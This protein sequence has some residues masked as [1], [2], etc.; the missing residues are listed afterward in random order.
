MS[1]P[2]IYNTPCTY[3]NI[4]ELQANIIFDV[5]NVTGIIKTESTLS[6]Y[7]DIELTQPEKDQ[8][9][10]TIANFTD[11][12]P[13]DLTPVIY[14]IAKAEA[15]KKHFHNIDYR[16]ELTRKLQKKSTIVKGEIVQV[17]WYTDVVLSESN[18]IPVR[19]Y[20]G[21]VMRVINSWTRD[22]SGFAITKNPTIRKYVMRNG[23]FHADEKNLG[24]PYYYEDYE[25]IEEGKKRRGLLVKSIQK[26]V[27][28]MM[29]QVL[30]PLGYS[31]EAVL[32]KGRTFLDDYDADF[33]KF[34][35]NSS[36]I[37]DPADPDFG[38]K[39]VVAKLE[40]EGK[41]LD[42]NGT[43]TLFG[44]VENL[45]WLDKAPASLGGTTTIRQY[46][47]GEFAI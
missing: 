9:D 2:F 4:T 20:S 26:P 43:P 47:T 5:P 27:L 7:S 30:L 28:Q 24:D 1:R 8:V 41:T 39:T 44:R 23:Q 37:N 17:D 38:K 18:G 35:N 31:Q 14:D 21:H 40:K 33:N 36:S 15:Q 22:A 13:D 46:L 32:L 42:V 12:N 34:I 3:L 25:Q 16:T 45:E 11:S 10:S 19:T 6:V 29:M